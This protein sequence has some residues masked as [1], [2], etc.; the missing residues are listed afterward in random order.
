[1]NPL[2][3]ETLVADRHVALRSSARSSLLRRRTASTAAGTGTAA[4]A[5]SPSTSTAHVGGNP[6][7]TTC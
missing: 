2:L 5:V 4:M 1:M 3:M 7:C 6:A